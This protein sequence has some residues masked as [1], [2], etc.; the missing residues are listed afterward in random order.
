MYCK[1]YLFLIFW[2]EGIITIKDVLSG[3]HAS[4]EICACVFVH[5]CIQPVR[6]QKCS[7]IIGLAKWETIGNIYACWEHFCVLCSFYL[8]KPQCDLT[9]FRKEGVSEESEPGIHVGKRKVVA[10]IEHIITFWWKI[11][12]DQSHTPGA[13]SRFWFLWLLRVFTVIVH[14]LWYKPKKEHYNLVLVCLTSLKKQNKQNL[15]LLCKVL[16]Q[17]LIPKSLGLCSLSCVF[18]VKS[19][20]NALKINHLCNLI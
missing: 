18:S 5:A 16:Q 4:V 2:K 7:N 12:M 13:C 17:I 1:I 10:V 19:L 6:S 14:F 9:G 11:S 3:Y 20:L 15:L 8:V